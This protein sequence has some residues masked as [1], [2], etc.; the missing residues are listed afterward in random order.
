[1]ALLLWARRARKP[2]N[3]GH[4]PGQEGD[5]IG[6]RRSAMRKGSSIAD[7]TGCDVGKDFVGEGA[8]RRYRLSLHSEGESSPGQVCH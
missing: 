3:G 4:R 8:G 6:L 5:Y 1:M 7:L 2:E